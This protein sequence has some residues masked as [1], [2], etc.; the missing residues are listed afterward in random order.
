MKDKIEGL[1]KNKEKNIETENIRQK[2][3]RK[4][5][6]FIRTEVQDRK[7]NNQTKISRD[8][9]CMTVQTE[10][11]YGVLS[12]LIDLKKFHYLDRSS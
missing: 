3:N 7:K 8:D 6:S 4:Y 2:V 10:K 1:S 5:G 12:R 11:T 9:K